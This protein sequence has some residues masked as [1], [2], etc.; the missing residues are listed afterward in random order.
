[1]RWP[2]RRHRRAN[3]PPRRL[4]LKV[5]AAASAFSWRRSAS[6]MC[7]PAL[8]RLAIALA[9]HAGIRFLKSM[10]G[11]IYA[12]ARLST[13]H[14]AWCK[15]PPST[16]QIAC[17]LLAIKVWLPGMVSNHL[18]ARKLIA[19]KERTENRLACEGAVQGLCAWLTAI[20]QQVRVESWT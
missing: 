7:L 20:A 18:S 14:E 1:V 3:Q 8:T 13:R 19:S 6:R 2:I 4:R 16:A 15:I 10:R 5:S 12:I 17:N 11:R 9:D